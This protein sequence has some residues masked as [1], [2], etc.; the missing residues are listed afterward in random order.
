MTCQIA[1]QLWCHN[2]MTSKSHM[3][4]HLSRIWRTVNWLCSVFVNL[5]VNWSEIK[6]TKFHLFESCVL[7]LKIALSASSNCFLS[8]IVQL[9]IKLSHN[10]SINVYATYII[11][12]LCN[13]GVEKLTITVFHNQSLISHIFWFITIIVL[14]I[15]ITDE[16]DICWCGRNVGSSSNG[17]A[18][19]HKG[20]PRGRHQGHRH[21]WGQQGT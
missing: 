21:H 18:G 12:G 15:I 14:Y 1:M 13:H 3:E 17:S 6:A 2:R 10:L 20:V 8:D 11:L 4:S 9:W 7:F 19:L 16:H 5:L